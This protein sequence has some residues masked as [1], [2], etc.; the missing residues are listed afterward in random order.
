MHLNQQFVFYLFGNFV[1]LLI[2][3]RT[4]YYYKYQ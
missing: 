2:H 3:Y 1:Y 4:P